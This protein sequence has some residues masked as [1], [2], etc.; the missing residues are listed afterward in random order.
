MLSD[1]VLGVT[2]FVAGTLESLDIVYAVGGSLATVVH[3]YV[4]NTN[5]ADIVA[6]MQL[7][8]VD[9]FVDILGDDFY[10]DPH[11]IRDAVAKRRSFNVIHL[12]TM[13]KVD[14]FVTRSR[15]FDQLQLERRI[16]RPI[17][18]R[19]RPLYVVTAEDAILAKLHWFRLGGEQSERQWR[20]VLEVIK[21][22]ADQLDIPYMQDT[23]TTLNVTD[24]V[25]KALSAAN[26]K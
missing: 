20:D 26:D 8:H 24:L 11:M 19:S 2:Y 9:L 25:D 22:Q 23:A 7:Q 3:G 18:E 10:A 15:R 16:Q 6:D 1:D 12:T 4:R 17:D 14:I 21:I 13:F 5:D